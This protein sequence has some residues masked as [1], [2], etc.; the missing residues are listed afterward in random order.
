MCWGDRLAEAVKTIRF[1]PSF[2]GSKKHWVSRLEHLI[3]GQPVIEYFCG[4]AVLSANLASNAILNDAD[5][6]LALALRRFDEQIVPE[7]FTEDDYYRVREE[8]DWWRY[9]F[10]LQRMSFSGVFR[11]SK[12]GYN[13]PV[14]KG[15]GSVSIQEEYASAL[16]RW[17]K[18]NPVVFNT[19]YANVGHYAADGRVAILDPPYEGSQASY[20]AKFS[21][22]AYWNF[23]DGLK[24]RAKAIVIF[25]RLVNLES[26]G[27]VP[28]ATRSMRVTGHYDGDVEAIGIYRSGAWMD[29]WEHTAK[30]TVKRRKKAT[31]KEAPK[32]EAPEKEAPKAEAPEKPKAEF[33]TLP[34]STPE[35][36]VA[37]E[38]V[39]NG[40]CKKCEE[41][42][43][44]IYKGKGRPR[45]RCDRCSRA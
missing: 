28:L 12:N 29:T 19:N 43:I 24:H 3:A 17:R 15:I 37:K 11:Y 39:R 8:P 18:L 22:E 36:A 16:E 5:P 26:R 2:V 13:V 35:K 10:C 38:S 20:N 23:V 14:K 30:K 40:I 7:V 45:V 27:I 6:M 42:F 1:L 32:A 21:Y 34:L 44:F 25:D 4:S 9:M 31:K 33:A 41:P